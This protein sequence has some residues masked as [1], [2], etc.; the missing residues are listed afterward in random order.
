MQKASQDKTL[1]REAMK[2]MKYLVKEYEQIKRKAHPKYAFLREFYRDKNIHR[3]NFIKYYNRYKQTKEE[4]SLLPQKRGPKYKTRRPSES[5]E[6]RV[7]SLRNLGTNRYEIHTILKP[8]LKELTPSPSGIYNIMKR[9]KVNKLTKPMKQ[10][11]QKIIKEKAGE[12]GHIDCHYLERGMIENDDNRYYLVGLIDDFSRVVHVEIVEDI[13]S[14][15]VMFSTLRILNIF[16]V[17]YKIKYEA[18]LSDNGPE[19]GGKKEQKN[20]EINP[21]KRLMKEME[22]KHLHTRPYRPQTNGKIERFWKTIKEDFLEEVVFDSMDHFKEELIQ[23]L[24]YFNN[25]RPHQGIDGKIPIEFLKSCHRI[26]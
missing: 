25:M 1:E 26:S 17:H 10:E 4:N 24:Y 23:Y 18:I 7:V 2:R 3:Q 5:I 11:H 19:F 14:L 13:K 22:I 9:Y 16:N 8:E 21:F 15:T 6:K 12:L 20:K